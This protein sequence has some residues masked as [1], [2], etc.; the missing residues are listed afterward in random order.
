LR[1]AALL[2]ALML[3]LSSTSPALT[4]VTVTLNYSYDDVE[5]RELSSTVQVGDVVYAAG[6]K[7]RYVFIAAYR[8]GGEAVGYHI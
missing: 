3:L 2:V 1:L 4:A 6:T 7:G 5:A 8:G